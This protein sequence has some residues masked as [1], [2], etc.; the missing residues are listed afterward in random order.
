MTSLPQLD[1]LF[2]TDG[3]LE[4]VLIFHRGRELPEFASFPEVLDE[5]GAE[6]IRRYYEPFLDLAAE[7]ELGFVCETPTW[8]ASDRWGER[9]GYSSEQM[10]A[11]N[12]KAVELMAGIRDRRPDQAI[13]LSG[14]IGPL[15]DGYDPAST[16]TPVEAEALHAPQVRTLADAGADMVSALTMTYAAEA[17]G[18]ARA[19][20]KAGIPAA[21]SFTV[22]TDGNLPD[23]TA[24]G[25]AIEAT[26]AATGGYPSY[27]MINCA[28]PSHFDSLFEEPAPWHARLRGLRANS[29]KASHAELD[30]MTELDEGDPADLGARHGALRERL[31][32]LTVLGGC[33]RHRPQARR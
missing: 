10:A 22:E 28:H 20:E 13:V 33:L 12:R 14:C 9:L 24:L 4:T 31:P 17:I 11:I 18:V 5:E 19:A 30:E 1:S 23:G 15:D 8:R 16:F 26:D 2:L 27:Y 7:H 6:E 21:I 3:G 29:S 32:H 25:D